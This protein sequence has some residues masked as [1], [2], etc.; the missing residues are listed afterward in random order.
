MHNYKRLD[1]LYKDKIANIS[2]KI[3]IKHIKINCNFKILSVT[4]PE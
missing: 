4:K 1:L 2:I 3:T